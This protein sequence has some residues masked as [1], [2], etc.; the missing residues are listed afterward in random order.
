MSLQR[1]FSI[2]SKSRSF[3]STQFDTPHVVYS[4]PRPPMRLDS[5]IF[6]G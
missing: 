2:V 5:D 4:R 3:D 6:R 1:R